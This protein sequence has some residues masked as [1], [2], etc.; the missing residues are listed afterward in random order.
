MNCR[1]QLL[2]SFCVTQRDAHVNNNVLF[3]CVLFFSNLVLFN[4]AMM[5]NV[6]VL[7]TIVTLKVAIVAK[8]L[9]T[10]LLTYLL[11]GA[12]SFLRS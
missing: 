5:R 11:H 7:R 3:A 10:Y 1:Q 2:L 4:G 12:E 6:N 9:L 8:Y